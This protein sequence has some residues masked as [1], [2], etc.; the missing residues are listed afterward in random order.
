MANDNDVTMADAAAPNSTN[1]NSKP[2]SGW[3]NGDVKQEMFPS[4]RNG[5]LQLYSANRRWIGLNRGWSRVG[6]DE[7]EGKTTDQYSHRTRRSSQMKSLLESAAA[8]AV[9]VASG[10]DN[11][12]T[13]NDNDND[14]ANANANA[15]DALLNQEARSVRCLIAQLSEQFYRLGWAAGTAGGVS[16]RVGGPDEKRPW[17]VFCM[18]SGIQKGE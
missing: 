7:G 18:P 16:I 13:V 3:S 1:I 5:K 15:N 4:T 14:A 8:A 6:G 11:D 10:D 17:R 2:G 12:D 9:A